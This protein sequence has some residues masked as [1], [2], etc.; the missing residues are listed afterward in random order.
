[1]G[2][3][4][5]SG[6][7][8]GDGIDREIAAQQVLFQGHIGRKSRLE[9]VIAR[10]GFTLCSRE[11]IFF[12]R[13]WMQEDRKILAHLPKAQDFHIGE[14]STDDD[15]V[16]LSDGQSQQSVPYSATNEIGFHGLILSGQPNA[17]VV[18]RH[19]RPK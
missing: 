11:R 16:S 5:F 19:G 8:L 9:T 3:D 6:A 17:R 15:P 18:R 14:R 7:R 13:L 4:Q 1:M 12:V 2:V 10:R